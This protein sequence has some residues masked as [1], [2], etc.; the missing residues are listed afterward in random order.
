MFRQLTFQ[1]LVVV[2]SVSLSACNSEGGGGGSDNKRPNSGATGV[3]ATITLSGDDTFVLGTTAEVNFYA[4]REDLAGSD[5][6]L[7][8]TSSGS[9]MNFVR[10]GLGELPESVLNPLDVISDESDAVVFNITDVGVSIRINKDGSS[11]LHST[12]CLSGCSGVQ[13]NV[14]SRTLVLDDLV[15]S[16]TGGDALASLTLNGTL[17]WAESDEDPDAAAIDTGTGTVDTGTSDVTLDDIVGVWDSGFGND[18]LYTVIKSNGTYIDYDYLG[19]SVDM[20]ENCYEK[21]EGTIQDYGNGQFLLDNVRLGTFTVSGDDLVFQAPEG[22]Y[23]LE[24]TTLLESDFVPL[25][26]E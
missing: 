10:V 17:V 13:F 19:D 21:D 18:E 20:G 4:F 7:S 9:A 12:I 8:A 26:D 22:P 2:V 16:P 23:T 15:L 24:S 11:Y 6:Y 14:A 25:C 1:L 5:L 3:A